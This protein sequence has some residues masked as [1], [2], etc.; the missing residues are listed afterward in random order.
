MPGLQEEIVKLDKRIEVLVDKI[1]AAKKEQPLPEEYIIT[2]G[3]Q[4]EELRKTKT[5]LFLN[6]QR[7]GIHFLCN[8]QSESNKMIHSKK[9]HLF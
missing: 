1:E 5:I 4:L 3:Q 7:A 6:S 2:L 9:I 8:K